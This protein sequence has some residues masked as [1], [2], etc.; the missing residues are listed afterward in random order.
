MARDRADFADLVL[1]GN[2]PERLRVVLGS[3]PLCRGLLALIND[4]EAGLS[5]L[6][7]LMNEVSKFDHVAALLRTNTRGRAV[8]NRSLLKSRFS[9]LSLPYDDKSV[10]VLAAFT[11]LILSRL[12]QTLLSDNRPDRYLVALLDELALIPK[13]VDLMLGAVK[14]REA[15]WAPV[16]AYQSPTMARVAF[17]RDRFDATVSTAKTFVVLNLPDPED[18][19][20]AAR[21]LGSRQGWMR[22]D[23]ASQ[24]TGQGG[25]SSTSGWS[26]NFTT[27]ENFTPSEIMALPVPT[28]ANPAITGVMATLPYKP[29]LFKVHIPT[30]LDRLVPKVPPA[31]PPAPRDPK[32]FLLTGWQA[33]DLK[34]L[35]LSR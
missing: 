34:R 15:G 2:D 14:G 4:T 13:G 16:F 27:L 6:A 20:W 11:R 8:S 30:L 10:E 9:V 33:D 35:R 32:D 5:V 12:Q 23:S 19:T 17:G 28:P 18:A 7:T 21:R 22:I 31:T 1:S 25:G 24:S 3:H 26:E 29:F